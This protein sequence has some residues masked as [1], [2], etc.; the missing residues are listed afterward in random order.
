MAQINDSTKEG[1][2]QKPVY[3]EERRPLKGSRRK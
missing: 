1:S 3:F 2:R